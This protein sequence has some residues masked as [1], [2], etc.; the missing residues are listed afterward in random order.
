[1]H[2]P[3]HITHSVPE[4]ARQLLGDLVGELARHSARRDQTQHDRA[5]AAPIIGHAT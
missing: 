4:L 3:I 1:V 5:I 2:L